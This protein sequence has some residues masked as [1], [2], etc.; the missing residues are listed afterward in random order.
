MRFFS[1]S[2]PHLPASASRP[3]RQPLRTGRDRPRSRP[4]SS[5]P[6]SSRISLKRR[7]PWGLLLLLLLWSIILGVGLAQA[8]IPASVETIAQVTNPAPEGLVDL[9]PER[10]QFGQELY[11]ENCATCHVGLPPATMPTESWREILT[12][13]YHYGVEITPLTQPA[14]QIAWNYVSF[15]SRPLR[16]DEPT[17]FRLKSS[18]YFKVLHPKVDFTSPITVRSCITCH[19]AAEQFN[20]RSLTPEWENAP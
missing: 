6:L 5:R 17:P 13:P 12:K 10:Y 20:Y 1:N 15:Y 11:L 4:S 19:P 9:V 8:T 3:E 16:E 7:S 14:L 18:R 2:S